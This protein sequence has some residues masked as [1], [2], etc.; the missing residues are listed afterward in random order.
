MT[1]WLMLGALLLVCAR[2]DPADAAL[3]VFLD[4]PGVNGETNA[5]GRPDVIALD[6]LTLAAGSFDAAK[7]VDST[8]P[9]LFAADATATPYAS[10]SL[11][12]YDSV[13]TDTQPDA[14]LVLHTALVSSIQSVLLGGNPGE[15]VSFVF[16]SPSV[17]LFLELPGV[18]GESSA[19]GHP[20]VIALDSFTLTPGGFTV[21]KAVNSTSPGLLNAEVLGHPYAAAS[22]LVYSDV[23]A[24]SEP[25]FAL[26][27][28]QALVSSIATQSLGNRPTEDVSFVTQGVT[29]TPE[30]ATAS[31]LV[32]AFAA[33]AVL[34]RA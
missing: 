22:L 9:A 16:A 24:Q 10:A 29:V 32:A 25:D 19:P 31:L 34:R 7:P 11:L 5:P 8:S 1:R 23:L 28:Q 3:S 12:F 14:Q 2:A 6:S 27:Y 17:S 4:L 33:A 18:T 21:H 20:G 13:A 26:V 15:L 30:P